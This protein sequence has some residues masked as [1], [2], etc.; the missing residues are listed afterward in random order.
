MKYTTYYEERNTITVGRYQ[1]LKQ[2]M[3]DEGQSYQT[4]RITLRK[5]KFIGNESQDSQADY[6][7]CMK[8]GDEEQVY[9]EKKYIQN[10]MYFKSILKISGEECRRILDGDLEWMK[11]HKKSLLA[12]FYRQ[13]TLN[14]LS[15]GYLTD[16]DREIN[17][18]KKGH[19]II[20]CKKNN[21]GVGITNRLFEEPKRVIPCLDEGK[22]LVTYQR[23]VKLPKI[24]SKLFNSQEEQPQEALS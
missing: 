5:L 2:R 9:L 15:P 13:I 20:F 16:Y 24:F 10:G 21:R 6:S 7:L 11:G 23:D 1:Q 4:E 12:D 22:M 3:L 19:R 18:S 8:N 17:Y 14:H